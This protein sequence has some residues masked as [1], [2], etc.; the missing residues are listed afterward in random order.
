LPTWANACLT[1][2]KRSSMRRTR[3]RAGR[4]ARR[5]ARCDDTYADDLY[6]FLT[7]CFHLKDWL[8]VDTAVPE[9][10]RKRVILDGEVPCSTRS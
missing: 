5:R 2:M 10:V 7:C 3:T 9:P 6:A 4:A 1:A 8:A